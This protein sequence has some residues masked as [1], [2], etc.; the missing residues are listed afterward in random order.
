MRKKIFGSALSFV[1]VCGYVHVASAAVCKVNGE[2]VPCDQ[3]GEKLSAAFAAMTIG[4]VIMGIVFLGGMIALTVFWIM[5]IIDAA[6]N[7]KESE[8]IAWIL[9]LVFVQILG[10]IIYYF[11]RKRPRDRQMALAQGNSFKEKI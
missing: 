3:I 9:V 1:S 6:K 4:M 10:A 7:E 8:L 5:M 11:V 2:I